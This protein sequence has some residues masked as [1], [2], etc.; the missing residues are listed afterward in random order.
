VNFLLKSGGYMFFAGLDVGSRSTKAVIVNADKEITAHAVVDTG[1]DGQKA[2]DDVLRI[3][4]EEGGIARQDVREIVSTGYGKG[5][6]STSTFRMTEISC[7]ARGAHHLFPETRTVIDI[8]GQDSK[9]I[10]LDGAG[11]V[12]DFAMN[13]RCAAGTGRFLEVMARAL[14]MDLDKMGSVPHDPAG[15]AVI[16]SLCT[17]FAES[18]VISLLSEGGTVESIVRGLHAAVAER[19]VALLKRIPFVPPITMTG[20]V[21]NNQGVV[22]A[23][24]A[25]LSSSLTLPE[26]PQMVGALGAA[27]MAH[28]RG[29]ERTT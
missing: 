1:V 15:T 24:R 23:L 19:T 22:Q 25:R 5:R 4:L 11:G 10:L 9:V 20:G 16:S 29:F 17:V 2:A 26:A 27:L 7:H 28:K 14:E 13:D 18:E 6:V 12:T 3:C 21:A 8:G